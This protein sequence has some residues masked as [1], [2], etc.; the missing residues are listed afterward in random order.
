[1]TYGGLLPN[2]GF[3]AVGIA[4]CCD[5]VYPND[6]RI[7]VP[8]LVVS[9]AVLGARTPVEAIHH[10][11]VAQRAAGYN[12]LLAHESGELYNVEVSAHRFAIL[13]AEDGYIAHTNHYLDFAMQAIE[14]EPD[15]LISSRVRYFRALRL[16]KQ[17]SSHSV[18]S[19]QTIQRDHINHPDS[20]CN[21]ATGYADPLDRQKTINAL[22][23]DLTA[24]VMH[25]AW[26]NPCEN[27]FHTYH[28]DV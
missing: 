25:L 23:I 16:L 3:N 20:I 6:C 28:L 5:T 27:P 18:K 19:L 1:M 2:I 8:R 21:H 4:Q 11:L 10:M 9:R 15:E 24:R 7:G 14:D 22:V 13:Y 12:H 17:T 26:G